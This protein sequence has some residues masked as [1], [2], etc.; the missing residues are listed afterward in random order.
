MALHQLF[1]LTGAFSQD[2]QRERGRAR[3]YPLCRP[4]WAEFSPTLF[5]VFIFLFLRGLENF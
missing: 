2:R 3:V 4:V 5:I 1:D